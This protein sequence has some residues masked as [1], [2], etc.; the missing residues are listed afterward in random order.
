M[1]YVQV[2]LIFFSLLEGRS[3]LS[4]SQ[5]VHSAGIGG[6]VDFIKNKDMATSPLA[7]EGF[8]LPLALNGLFLDDN[9][10]NRFQVSVILP[11]LANN[12]PLRSKAKTKLVTWSKVTVGYQ[13]LKNIGNLNYI[14]GG[15]G[16]DMFY[17]EY[18][19]LDGFG[20]ELQAGFDLNYA[21]KI[22]INEHSFLL[23]QLELPIFSFI[24][25][26]P[27]LTLDE[28]FLDHFHHENYS[29]MLKEGSWSLIFNDWMAIELRLLYHIQ[30]WEKVS[31]QFQTGVNYYAITRPEKVYHLNVPFL[32]FVN[33]HF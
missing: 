4:Q 11:I 24:H 29:E 15:L 1:K 19:F 20:W 10:M 9:W 12:Y 2:V 6:G 3:V 14:G 23:P 28:A 5:E 33:Y 32:C 31:L 26:K 22:P 8:G 17:R 13:I 27:S 25:R 16:I 30:P 21:R 18:P 7:Y